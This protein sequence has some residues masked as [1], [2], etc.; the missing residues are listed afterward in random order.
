MFA[1]VASVVKGL[2]NSFVFILISVVK[3]ESCN[4][5]TCT[6]CYFDSFKY[7]QPAVAC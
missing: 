5:N 6:C 1:L 4:A 7:R 3:N 2:I